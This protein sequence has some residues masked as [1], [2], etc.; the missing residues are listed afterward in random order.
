MK[1][2]IQSFIKSIGDSGCLVLCMIKI[3]EIHRQRIY[4]PFEVI[5]RALEEDWLSEDMF[6]KNPEA[7]MQFLTDERWEYS[8][9][10]ISTPRVNGKVYCIERWER[11][12][13]AGTTSHFRLPEWDP[14]K[15]SQ[16]VKYG[17]IASYRILRKVS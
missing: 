2:G 10:S 13:T 4:N 3:A 6:V 5:S 7:I 17:R 15:D 8:H 16:T 1:Q 11:S 12:T 9:N 14:L